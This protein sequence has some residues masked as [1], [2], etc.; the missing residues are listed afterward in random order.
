MYQEQLHEGKT[1]IEE[2]LANA[3][4]I[5]PTIAGKDEVTAAEDG[6]LKAAST[7]LEEKRSEVDDNLQA[8]Q[9]T[10]ESVSEVHVRSLA[11]SQP[12]S[13]PFSLQYARAI[14]A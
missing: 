7:F 6:V 1:V 14:E 13:L 5:L 12:Q 11:C 9:A 8:S 2:S 10:K 3:E 4:G